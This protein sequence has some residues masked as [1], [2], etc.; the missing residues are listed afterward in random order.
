M[1]LIGLN[2]TQISKNNFNGGNENM[3]TKE[4]QEFVEQI[5]EYKKLIAEAQEG[6]DAAIENLEEALEELDEEE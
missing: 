1:L 2:K 3:P 5:E 4:I 6:L